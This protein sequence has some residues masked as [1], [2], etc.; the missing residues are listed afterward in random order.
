MK[1]TGFFDIQWNENKT[2]ILSAL[3][4]K[5]YIRLRKVYFF[6]LYIM[7]IE[8]IKLMCATTFKVDAHEA[9]KKVL[10]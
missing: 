5:S 3:W 10:K 2:E 7:D 8:Y 1:K 6:G 4:E 9:I